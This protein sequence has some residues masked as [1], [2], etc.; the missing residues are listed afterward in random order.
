MSHH[1]VCGL[2]HTLIISK[3]ELLHSIIKPIIV[4][5][6]ESLGCGWCRG[7]MRYSGWVSTLCS[8]SETASLFF[9]LND[10]VNYPSKSTC[11]LLV[12]AGF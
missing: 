11:S 5:K 1:V 8:R 9:I 7:C 10:G 4:D 6:S 3:C 2:K 12:N